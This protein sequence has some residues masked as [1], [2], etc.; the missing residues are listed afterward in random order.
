MIIGEGRCKDLVRFEEA[1]VFP[2]TETLSHQARKYIRWDFWAA[3]GADYM[4]ATRQF[5]LYK[6]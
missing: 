4:V 1:G 6:P 5:Q 2:S 3:S